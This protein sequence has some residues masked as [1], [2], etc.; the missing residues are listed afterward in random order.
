M[1]SFETQFY[2]IQ[3][4]V[5]FSVCARTVSYSLSTF[6]TE[7]SMEI[8]SQQHQQL[9]FQNNCI[10]LVEIKSRDAFF[11][12]CEVRRRIPRRLHLAGSLL[13]LVSRRPYCINQ[14][15]K[16][17]NLIIRLLVLFS[18]NCANGLSA[19]ICVYIYYYLI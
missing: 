16:K 3:K 1:L 11:M 12:L 9:R 6:L 7:F 2:H 17:S 13:A 10:L 15:G 8:D 4:H 18:N 5:H 14:N 19:K